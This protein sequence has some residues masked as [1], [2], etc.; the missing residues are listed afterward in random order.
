M[1]QTF[2]IAVLAGDGIGPEITEQ[3]MRVLT[4]IEQKRDVVFD[5]QAAEFGASAYFSTG[6]SFPDATK[7]ACDEAD[8][9]LKGPIGL[10]HILV[11]H[12]GVKRADDVTRSRE[13]ACIRAMEALEK[14][15]A[16]DDWDEVVADYS[17]ERGAAT[18][19][20]S[21]GEALHVLTALRAGP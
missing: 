14:L 18:R 5:C 3:A 17:D 15:K 4:L 10:N 6:K 1:T 13:E 7:K 2:K 19:S 21:L 20:G 8:A 9:I 11:R 16:G 12:E